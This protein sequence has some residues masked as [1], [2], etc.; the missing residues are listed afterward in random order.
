MRAR[1]SSRRTANQRSRVCVVA[2]VVVAQR[3]CQMPTIHTKG[4]ARGLL[5]SAICH[6]RPRKCA[7]NAPAYHRMLTEYGDPAARSDA[8]QR[9]HCF[10]L[11]HARV[12]KWR[13][14]RQS[15]KA[16]MCRPPA[17]GMGRATRPVRLTRRSLCLLRSSQ[18]LSDCAVA[19]LHELPSLNMLFISGAAAGEQRPSPK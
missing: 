7:C 10:S 14:Q 19:R 6:A 8:A 2:E 12:T 15:M 18:S 5:P 9:I 4:Q 11:Y 16:C 1:Q 17:R 13:A 3:Y